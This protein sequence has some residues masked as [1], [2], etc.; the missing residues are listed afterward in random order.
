MEW[1]SKDESEASITGSARCS[2]CSSTATTSSSTVASWAA[3]TRLS[4]DSQAL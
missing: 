2:S 4:I 1:F 3:A